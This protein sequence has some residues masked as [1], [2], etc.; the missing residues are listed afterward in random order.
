MKNLIWLASFP[1][2]GNTWLRA[3][4]DSILGY[5]ALSDKQSLS[6]I[7]SSCSSRYLWPELF[8]ADAYPQSD[9]TMAWRGAYQ[10]A[11]SEKIG[12]TRHFCKTHSLYGSVIGNPMIDPDVSRI[13]VVIVRNPFDVAASFANYF[14]TT[15]EKGMLVISNPQLVINNAGDANH[16]QVLVGSWD[17]NVVSWVTQEDIPMLILRYE[18]MFADP[19][20]QFGTV[21]RE[22]LG[23]TDEAKIR[24]AVEDTHFSKL[25]AR[26]Q[27]FGFEEAKSKV[28]PF[29][30]RGYPYHS[31][32]LFTPEQQAY[33]WDR[34]G[35]TAEAMGYRFENG[36]LSLE[37]MDMDKLKA[38]RKLYEPV[39][40]TMKVVG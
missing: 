24:A 36:K 7:S 9:M 17:V 22:V 2:S 28:N 19:V 13:A 20:T 37:A 38:L 27:K 29:F 16:N 15:P 30:W 31:L 4:I 10:R 26:E 6:N 35:A 23:I 12:T 34:H 32:E 3:F 14:T 11:L 33:I 21:A 40:N 18:D 1:K 39:I 8:P 5:G 25:K